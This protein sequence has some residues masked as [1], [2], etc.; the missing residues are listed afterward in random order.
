[1]SRDNLMEGLQCTYAYWKFLVDVINDYAPENITPL[2]LGLDPLYAAA[3]GGVDI[4]TMFRQKPDVYWRSESA[5]AA[6]ILMMRTAYL[7]DTATYDA[8]AH[9]AK[10]MSKILTYADLCTQNTLLDEKPEEFKHEPLSDVDGV[11]NAHQLGY[12]KYPGRLTD[13]ILKLEAIVAAKW[14]NIYIQPAPKRQN[15]GLKLV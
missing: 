9:D 8:A 10:F 14:R 6:A 7:R 12:E 5:R 4:V 11:G 3:I 2:P 13:D 15:P 1:L